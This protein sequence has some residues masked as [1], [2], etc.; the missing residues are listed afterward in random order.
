MKTQL[1]KAM[2]AS[3]PVSI[4]LLFAVSLILQGMGQAQTVARATGHREVH[5]TA[6]VVIKPDPQRKREVRVEIGS[7]ERP[8]LGVFLDDLNF[9]T[10]YKRHYNHNYGVLVTGVVDGGP[11]QQ[12]GLMKGDILM[13]FDGTEI[14]YADQLER[15]LNTKQAGETVTMQYYRDGTVNKAQVT[16]QGPE[17]KEQEVRH[18]S[19]E[20]RPFS[21][22]TGG[23]G[24]GFQTTWYAPDHAAIS[25]LLSSLGF[26]DV[27]S[28]PP[29]TS[30]PPDRGMLMR[31]FHFQFE[32]GNHWY[33][34]FSFNNYK[35][36][37]RQA[38]Q[39]IRQLDYKF[40]YWGF[41]MNRR[42]SFFRLLT[43]DTGLLAGTGSYK[44]QLLET[45]ENPSWP[46]LASQLDN[47][48]NNYLE[49]KKKY[50]IL[51]PSAAATVN[52]TSWFA[53]QG[54]VGYLWGY[55]LKNGWSAKVVGDSYEVANSPETEVSSPT[56]SL[57]LWFDI[58]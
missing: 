7:S 19:Y 37:N 55:P 35:V 3:K 13:D 29:L 58:F 27:L 40:G 11:A 22:N 44:I 16:L 20:F 5:E 26:S 12:A 28:D 32:N 52:F 1:T 38:G 54:R 45:H 4:A 25:Q 53:I 48:L 50:I 49:L 43:L 57:S 34:G 42:I 6:S 14:R 21:A 17:E 2:Q 56:Y 18:M 31:G 46:N 33:W 15:L 24:F 36:S 41:T 9:E 51:Q 23:G 8:Q 39:T 47:S 10:A 30:L